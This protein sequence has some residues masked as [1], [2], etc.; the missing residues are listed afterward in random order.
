[1]GIRDSGINASHRSKGASSPSSPDVP[2]VG[3]LIHDQHKRS[4]E[5]AWEHTQDSC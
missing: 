4:W 3:G 1:M 2:F 5:E